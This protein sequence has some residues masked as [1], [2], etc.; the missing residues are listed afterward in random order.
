MNTLPC[1]RQIEPVGETHVLSHASLGLQ[2]WPPG[3][4]LAPPSGSLYYRSILVALKSAP[5]S[6]AQTSFPYIFQSG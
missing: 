4:A 1:H 2:D 5:A 6:A 3:P